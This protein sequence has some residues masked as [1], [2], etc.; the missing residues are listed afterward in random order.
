MLTN[1]TSRYYWNVRLFAIAFPSKPL[2][3]HTIGVLSQR[4]PQKVL[5]PALCPVHL[6]LTVDRVLHSRRI[7]RSIPRYKTASLD[8]HHQFQYAVLPGHSV[9][10][11]GVQRE[12]TVMFKH[13]QGGSGFCDYDCGRWCCR[14]SKRAAG[15]RGFNAT[16]AVGR[17]LRFIVGTEVYELAMQARFHQI[18]YPTWVRV[19]LVVHAVCHIS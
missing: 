19:L 1:F 12:Q 16:E 15:D 7:L 18:G 4:S 6:L 17:N 14:K 9:G 13:S 10:A 8:A 3:K 2:S 11:R 5:P